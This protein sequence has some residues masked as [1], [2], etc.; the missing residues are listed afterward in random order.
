MPLTSMAAGINNGDF[1]TGDFTGWSLDTDGASGTTPDFQVEP[2]G[3]DYHARIEADY[4]STPGD[5]SSTPQD[6]VLFANTLYQ[7]LDLSAAPGAQLLLSFD[8]EFG[9]ENASFDENLVFALGDGKGDF[10]DADGNLGFLLNPSSYGSGTFSVMLDSAFNNTSNW[11][12]IGLQMSAGFD[13][14]GSYVNIDNV[15]LTA[16]SPTP[17]VPG[18]TPHP[19]PLAFAPLLSSAVLL[20]FGMAASRKRKA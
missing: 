10:Y 8:W 11:W 17:P 5:T 15:T 16:T 4:W 18:G 9:G 19:V 12:A 2:S 7:K 1:A 13:G 14:N 3:T 6:Q 20:V